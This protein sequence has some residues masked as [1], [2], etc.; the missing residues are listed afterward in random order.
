[1]SVGADRERRTSNIEH[2]TLNI[3]LK[4]TGAELLEGTVENLMWNSGDF[5]PTVC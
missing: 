4:S 2:P 3:E 5:L 1:M